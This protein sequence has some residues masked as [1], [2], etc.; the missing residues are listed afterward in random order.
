MWSSFDTSLDQK[1]EEFNYFPFT[2]GLKLAIESNL[3][4]EPGGNFS[5]VGGLVWT[6]DSMASLKF[7]VERRKNTKKVE[8]VVIT[9]HKSCFS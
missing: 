2:E 4:I 1:L 8:K 6:T 9:T 7:V 3:N 5:R